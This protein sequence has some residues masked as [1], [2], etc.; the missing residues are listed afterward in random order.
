MQE[1]LTLEQVAEADANFRSEAAANSLNFNPVVEAAALHECFKKHSSSPHNTALWTKLTPSYNNI[2]TDD[3]AAL[4]NAIHKIVTDCDAQHLRPTSI[5]ARLD[6][7]VHQA[8]FG[9]KGLLDHMKPPS[10]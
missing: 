1:G 8:V 7:G 9:V 2:K 6:S 10:S 3:D 5:L 4:G